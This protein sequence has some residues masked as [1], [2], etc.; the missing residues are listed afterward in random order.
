MV[1]EFQEFFV[2]DDRYSQTAALLLDRLVRQGR[3]FGIHVLLGSQTLGGAYSLARTTIGQMA[4]RIALQ[5]SD[6]DAHLILSE[7]NTAARLL[8]RPGEA[9][10]NDANGM[11]EG[12]NPFQVAWLDDNQRDA[13][14]ERIQSMSI[15]SGRPR[16]EAIVFE[17]NIPADPSRNVELCELIE[18]AASH[19]ETGHQ[20]ELNPRAWLGDAVAIT[21]PT[22]VTFSRRSGA[23]LLLVGPDEVATRGILQTAFIALA[24][25]SRHV[26]DAE[27]SEGAPAAAPQLYVLREDP[28]LEVSASE[29]ATR[30]SSLLQI[31]RKQVTVSGPDSAAKVLEEIAAE[32]ARRRQDRT[33]APSVFLV[34]DDLSRFRDLRKSEDDF[35]FGKSSHDKGPSPGTMFAE[36]LREGP[37]VGVHVLV[38]CDSYNNV[39]RWFNRQSLREFEMRVV[40]QMSAADSSHLIDSPAASRLGTNRALFYSDERGTIE[41]FRPYGLPADSWLAWLRQT[42]SPAEA[43]EPEEPAIADDI[44]QWLVT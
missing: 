44:D 43:A 24:A 34:I 42:L 31:L 14:L 36:I 17:G 2:E 13:F 33:A 30:W 21:G 27:P 4:V 26:S 1:D 11:L 41:K 10:Y 19:R 32:V 20:A 29:D 25:Q 6:T 37:A 8:T 7:N 23:N 12:N 5:C 3:A 9:I 18:S 22:R 16:N 39:D 15:E 35:G 40:L 28:D 38:W